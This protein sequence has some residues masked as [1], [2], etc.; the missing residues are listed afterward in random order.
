MTLKTLIA[1][2]EPLAR[3][4]LR[5]LLSVYTDIEVIEECRN[6]N[7]VVSFLKTK[8]ADLVFLDIQMPGSNGLEVIEAVGVMHMPLTVFVTAYNTFAVQAFEV[9]ALDYLIKPISSER[10]QAAVA[11]VRKRI[12]AESALSVQAQLN[13]LLQHVKVGSPSTNSFP[14]RLLVPNGSE[15][16]FIA[17]E[18]IEWIEAADDY[19]CLHIGGRTFMLRE[20]IRQ[21]EATL[22][23]KRFVRV[24]RSAIVNVRYV[25]KILREG[26]E[27]AWLT[28]IN[29]ARVKMSKIG[30]QNLMATTSADP[31]SKHANRRSGQ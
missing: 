10:L 14:E 1:D 27:D 19:A 8:P 23:P 26:R 30:W 2:D 20:T 25:S 4:R 16:I 22:D 6:G 3:K 29:G 17:T 9:H 18:D 21:L 24:H 5:Q 12:A 28:L 31:Q 11:Q 13:N 7:E 15:G